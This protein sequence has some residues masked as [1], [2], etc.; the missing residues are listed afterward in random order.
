MPEGMDPYDVFPACAGMSPILKASLC[1]VGSFPRMRGDEPQM[2]A[3]TSNE[4]S[5]SPH[6]RG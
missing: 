3:Q 4:Q 5:F 2:K 6:A 1:T